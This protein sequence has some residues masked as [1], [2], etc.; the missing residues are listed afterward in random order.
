M[1]SITSIRKSNI[2]RPLAIGVNNLDIYLLQGRVFPEFEANWGKPP[3]AARASELQKRGK[4]TLSVN[5]S[6]LS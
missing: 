1:S 5:K 6:D 2:A 4:R 3:Q